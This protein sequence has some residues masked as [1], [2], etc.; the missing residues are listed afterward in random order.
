VKLRQQKSHN[1]VAK[2][3]R[4]FDFQDGGTTLYRKFLKSWNFVGQCGLEGQYKSLW[5]IQQQSVLPYK[6]DI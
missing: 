2:M 4:V 1:T 6:R 5:L 3:W